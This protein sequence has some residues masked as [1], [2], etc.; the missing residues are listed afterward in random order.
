M[1]YDKY[2][3]DFLDG[4]LDKSLED[5]LFRALKANDEIRSKMKLFLKMNSVSKE[6]LNLINIPEKTTASI[7]NQL[8]L[9][10][11]FSSIKKELNV[12]DSDKSKHNKY[13]LIPIIFMAV[14]LG[15]YGGYLFFNG[16][17]I[18]SGINNSESLA[19]SSST[20]INTKNNKPL[21]SEEHQ[22][23][24]NIL[25]KSEKKST[26]Q[27]M[28]NEIKTKEYNNNNN[29]EINLQNKNQLNSIAANNNVAKSELLTNKLKLYSPDKTQLIKCFSKNF[30]YSITDDINQYYEDNSKFL[31][32]VNKSDYVHLKD[33]SGNK[34]VYQNNS[35][36]DFGLTAIYFINA[37]IGIGYEFKIEEFGENIYDEINNVNVFKYQSGQSHSILVR[38]ESRYEN[39]LTPFGQMSFGMLNDGYV[40]KLSTGAR[41]DLYDNFSLSFCI[42]Y[43]NFINNYLGN[44]RGF[45]KLGIKYGLSYKF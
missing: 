12:N 42:E 23:K 2:I 21:L 29:N 37:N 43:G 20:E 5:E 11:E 31:I 10:N 33:Q 27:S 8:G 35:F 44:L 3:I 18:E 22:S 13:L 34:D 7:F 36:L 41:Y 16:R 19:T 4:D 9:E 28:N 38:L 24:L 6:H 32:E 15:F 25:H 30:E 45:Q 26:I 17:N 1:K 39:N 40:L 14:L